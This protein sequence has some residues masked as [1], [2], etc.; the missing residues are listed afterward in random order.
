[1]TLGVLAPYRGLGVG[2]SL[3]LSLFLYLEITRESFLWGLERVSMAG[4]TEKGNVC[5]GRIRICGNV[6][7]SSGLVLGDW[8]REMFLACRPVGHLLHYCF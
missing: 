1:M 6:K 2:K 5:R 4:V 8:T 7:W 3:S